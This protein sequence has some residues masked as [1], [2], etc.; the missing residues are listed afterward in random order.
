M[1]YTGGPIGIVAIIIIGGLLIFSIVMLVRSIN[2]YNSKKNEWEELR[3]RREQAMRERQKQERE[4][5][6]KYDNAVLSMMEENSSSN[7]TKDDWE[8]KINQLK[9]LLDCGAI[10]DEEYQHEKNKY[11]GL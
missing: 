2:D 1:T 3:K 11:L 8:K 9:E 4:A 7:E 6:A 5:I 10:T